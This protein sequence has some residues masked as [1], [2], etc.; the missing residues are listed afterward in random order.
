MKTLLFAIVLIFPFS[1]FCQ[2]LNQDSVLINEKAVNW[3]KTDYV[4]KT[5][6]DP[7]S[8]KLVKVSNTL[9]TFKQWLLNDLISIN[10]TISGYELKKKLDKYDKE[11]YEGA[12]K[13]KINYETRLKE[14]S[15]D[16]GAKTKCYTIL[17]DCYGANSYGN[18]VLGRYSFNF[19]TD[20]IPP[21]TYVD[22][23]N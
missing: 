9:I 11:L 23:I 16:E 5:F 12:V 3:F 7:Y 8:Y 15:T 20:K 22:K 19:F 18:A 4:E 17:I 14:L 6:K 2:T 21:V 13:R 10:K 1:G